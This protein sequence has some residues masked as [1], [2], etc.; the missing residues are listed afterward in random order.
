[1]GHVRLDKRG[2]FPK[3]IFY[4]GNGKKDIPA[5]FVQLPNLEYQTILDAITPILE[6]LRKE[7]PLLEIVP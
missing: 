1:M 2:E 6:E 3:L 4:I 5:T 7:A